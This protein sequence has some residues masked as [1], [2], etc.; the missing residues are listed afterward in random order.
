MTWFSAL[1][2]YLMVFWTV[3]FA[4]LPWGNRAHE[5]HDKGLAGSAPRNPRIKQKFLITGAIA[6][7]IWAVICLLIIYDAVDLFEMGREMAVEDY[8]Q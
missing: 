1:V 8:G 6:T 7:V 4:I 5:E 2:V 3:L